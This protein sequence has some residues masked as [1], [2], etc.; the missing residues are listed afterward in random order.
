[1]AY[2]KL[3][4]AVIP[5]TMIRYYTL[6]IIVLVALCN[7]AKAQ[8]ATFASWVIDSTTSNLEVVT[9]ADING[10]GLLDVVGATTISDY[11][12]YIWFQKPNGT[13]DKPLKF[14]HISQGRASTITAED[15]NKDGLPEIILCVGNYN[16]GNHVTV[17]SWINNTLVL[18][19]SIQTHTKYLASGVVTGD[20]DTDGLIDIGVSHWGG[21]RITILFRNKENNPKWDIRDYTTPTNGFGHAVAGKFGTLQ[22]TAFIH[23]NG[24]HSN[25]VTILTFDTLRNIQNKYDLQ[26]P[27]S[28]S[29]RAVAIVKKGPGKPAELWVSYGGNKP[30]SRISIWRGLQ[31]LPD[32]TFVTYDLPEALESANLDCDIDDE[33][34]VLHGGW[35]RATVY[36]DSADAH[37]I[38]TPSHYN[39]DGLALGDINND[40]FI[41]ICIANSGYPR[42]LVILYNTTARPCWPADIQQIGTTKKELSIFPNPA[43]K[44]TTIRYRSQGKLIVRNIIGGKVFSSHFENEI[45]IN[46]E[47]WPKGIYTVTLQGSDSQLIIR[48]LQIH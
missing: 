29:G 9:T 37:S 14:P 39:P 8:H 38:F 16:V 35:Q 18:E 2:K 10:D 32:S 15:L 28:N 6:A 44:T 5:Y 20:F 45:N 31:T 22:Q 13:I 47:N 23:I 42:G 3:N 26:L 1:M 27:S 46:T 19:D 11:S 48:K 36:T 33:P 24:Q 30:D 7:S 40:D 4:L 21:D 34:V 12:I 25:P 41:D 43:K 17:Y